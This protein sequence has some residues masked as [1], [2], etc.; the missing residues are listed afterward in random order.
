[1][2]A[3]GSCVE[4]GRDTKVR[5]SEC[6]GAE[7]AVKQ[8]RA[9]RLRAVADKYETLAQTIPIGV[10]LSDATGDTVFV[11]D[12]WC[13]Q[14]GLAREEA[15]G[16]GWL[17]SVHPEDRARIRDGWRDALDAGEGVYRAEC[18]RVRPDGRVLWSISAARAL[19]DAEGEIVGFLGTVIDVT[20]LKEA[21]ARLESALVEQR[22]AVDRE[23]LLRRELDHRVG[24]NL[25]ALLG[26]IRVCEEG[27][28]SRGDLALRLRTMVSAMGRAH[29]IISRSPGAPVC[30]EKFLEEMARSATGAQAG[31]EVRMG[32]PP[33][34]VDKGRVN[35]LAMVVQELLTNSAK[36]GALGRPA[37]RVEVSWVEEGAGRVRVEWREVGVGRV[38]TPRVGS[39]L[40]IVRMLV[41]GDLGGGIDLDGGEDGLVCVIRA[42]TG[43][44]RPVGPG[45]GEANQ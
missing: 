16:W 13:E 41:E 35:A 29:R 8:E 23:R 21:Q 6:A 5:G 40:S 27:P 7:S 15:L 33:V 24:N 12:L 34:C 10:Y 28:G 18:R 9:R 11:N 31:C 43:P 1:M 19:R 14:M 20:E 2:D 44:N 42:R 39:G 45:P 32:G 30:L 36:H 25:S 22:V 17:R 3:N 38:E 26:L 4:L 37:G